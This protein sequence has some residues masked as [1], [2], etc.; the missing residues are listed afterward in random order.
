MLAKL[1]TCS[2]LLPYNSVSRF[3]P[4]Q[5]LETLTM[6]LEAVAL[7]KVTHILI[8]DNDIAK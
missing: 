7:A 5:S 2:R 4:Q 8:S 3:H 1:N 6:P